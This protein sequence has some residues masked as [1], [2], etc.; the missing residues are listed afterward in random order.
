MPQKSSAGDH[1]FLTLAIGSALLG[2]GWLGVLKYEQGGFGTVS[3]CFAVTLSL[4]YAYLHRHDWTMFAAT[5]TMI[6]LAFGWCA[7][8][9][10]FARGLRMSRFPAGA[11]LLGL[12]PEIYQTVAK[13]HFSHD[14]NE[15][16]T[17]LTCVG[18]GVMGITCA[19]EMFSLRRATDENAL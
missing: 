16:L 7:A 1:A 11:A 14:M 4:A 5:G 17:M 13:H 18:L 10:M 15:M 9:H 2:V 6:L 12:I 8:G 19:F 3:G